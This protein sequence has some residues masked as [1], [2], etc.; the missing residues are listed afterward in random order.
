MREKYVNI[1][2]ENVDIKDKPNFAV[3]GT[4]FDPLTNYDYASIMH[5]PSVSL[6]ITGRPTI[7]P[8]DP[9]YSYTIGQRDEIQF[10]DWKA[11]NKAYC[12]GKPFFCSIATLKKVFC[13]L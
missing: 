9:L 8:K 5:Y 12:G 3:M 13:C 1:Y 6:S 11:I 2:L 4:L 7:I 10:S